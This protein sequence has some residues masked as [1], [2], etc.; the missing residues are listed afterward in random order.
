MPPPNLK[1]GDVIYGWLLTLQKHHCAMK[2]AFYEVSW[3]FEFLFGNQNPPYRPSALVCI[4]SSYFLQ[5]VGYERNTL[6]IIKGYLKLFMGSFMYYVIMFWDFSDPSPLPFLIIRLVLN[7]IK[8]CHFLTLPT[9][10]CD[11]V[12][13]GYSLINRKSQPGTYYFLWM[14]N[15]N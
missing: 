1:D 13:H 3:V 11:Y 6:V 2:N 15:S 7:V 10:F 14:Q 5:W 12:I 8:N 9:P 4:I